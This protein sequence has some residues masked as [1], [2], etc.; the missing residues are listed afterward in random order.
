MTELTTFE[1]AKAI[2]KTLLRLVGESLTYETW[3]DDF[4]LSNIKSINKTLETWSKEY[5]TFKIN[6]NDLSEKEINELEFG[7]WSDDSLVRLIPIWLYPFLADEFES[8]SISGSKHLK[9]SDIDNDHR[10]GYLA[11]GVIPKN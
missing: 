7:K 1:K 5:G 10:F 2:K 3:S 6:P 8:I 9:L 11:Y 4:K